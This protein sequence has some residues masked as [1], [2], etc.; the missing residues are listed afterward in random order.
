MIKQVSL[1]LD[2]ITLKYVCSSYSIFIAI[3]FVEKFIKH[4]LLEFIAIRTVHEIVFCQEEAFALGT[5]AL[6]SIHSALLVHHN[7]LQAKGI[8]FRQN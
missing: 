8:I 3:L 5:N 1:L 4:L 6:N 7:L 2:E